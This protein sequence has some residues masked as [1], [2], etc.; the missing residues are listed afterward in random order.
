MS[1]LPWNLIKLQN[2]G[3]IKTF[4]PPILKSQAQE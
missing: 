4:M 3:A 1:T 2:K